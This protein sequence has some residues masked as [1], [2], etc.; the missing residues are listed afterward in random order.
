MISSTFPGSMIA[1]QVNGGEIDIHTVPPTT[2]TTTAASTP[3]VPATRT[4]RGTPAIARAA[5]PRGTH[6]G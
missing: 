1:S 3:S 4:L 5:R 2:V 6:P